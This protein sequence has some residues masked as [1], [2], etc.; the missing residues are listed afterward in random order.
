MRTRLRVPAMPLL[1]ITNSS[2]SDCTRSR[3][4]SVRLASLSARAVIRACTR[5]S[6]KL[7]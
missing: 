2:R 3:S 1:P 6:R 4:S 5:I 7:C